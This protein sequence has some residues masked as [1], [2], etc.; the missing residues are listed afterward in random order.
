[1]TYMRL[2]MAS[3]TIMAIFRVTDQKTSNSLN[4][5]NLVSDL[6]DEK[7]LDEIILYKQKDFSK[8][9]DN[10]EKN[11]E[12]NSRQYA[13]EFLDTFPLD[14]KQPS[15]LT[16]KKILLFREQYKPLRD[17]LLAHSLKHAKL[18][19]PTINEINEVVNLLVIQANQVHYIYSGSDEKLDKFFENQ[20]KE[21]LELWD[22][23][24]E[25]LSRV[26]GNK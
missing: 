7:F 3:D 14:W 26:V 22:L 1:M 8:F 13:K 4:F 6:T 19:E 25:G 17:N 5:C 10:F 11:Y 18:S 15:N 23:F 21:A 20:N 12:D 24:E 16:N 2:V 9:G